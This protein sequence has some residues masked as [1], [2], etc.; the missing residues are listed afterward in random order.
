MSKTLGLL[1]RTV[2]SITH[3]FRP[4]ASKGL[5][6]MKKHE[7]ILKLFN[8]R[9]ASIS[10]HKKAAGDTPAR[11]FNATASYQSPAPEPPVED[12]G[13]QS[14]AYLGTTKRLPEFSLANR[15]IVVTGGARGIGLIQA[16][17]LLE[18]GATV[19]ALDK[20]P[21]PSAEFDVVQRRARKELGGRLHY[22]Q[23]DVRQDQEL[24]KVFR[25]IG[26]EHG[27]LDGLVAGAAYQQE[28]SALDYRA[29]EATEMFEVNITGVLMTAQAAA[30]QMIRFGN[31]G[32]I[33]M[34][35]SMSG[36]VANREL[37]SAAYNA[38]KGGV[39]Q[40]GRNLAMEWAEHK[41]R[42]NTLSPGYTKTT[43]VTE[44][45]KTHPERE[46]FW[47]SQNMMNRLSKPEEYRGAV[48]FLL[49]DASSFMT[50][51]DLRIDGGHCAW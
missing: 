2:S 10:L 32:S 49:S 29:K 4:V 41:I 12:K 46:S 9:R 8:S 3:A 36:T 11:R 40:L 20:E 22:R 18:A 17:A 26:D 14:T 42:V 6:R 50:G 39:L 37:I 28:I 33:V 5:A 23:L 7:D 21:E 31:G 47:E 27:R 35:G 19:Y 25:E 16:E 1:P 15:V 43:M 44:L 24:P 48:V 30:K 51:S 13:Q 45:F 38:S 34:I